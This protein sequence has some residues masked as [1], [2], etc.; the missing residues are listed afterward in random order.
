MI[1]VLLRYTE[2]PLCPVEAGN[3]SINRSKRIQGCEDLNDQQCGYALQQVIR[4]I[5]GPQRTQS[6]TV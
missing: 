1:L 4:G 5:L 2:F 3:F 6:A